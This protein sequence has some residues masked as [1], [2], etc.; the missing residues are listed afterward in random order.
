V[1]AARERFRGPSTSVHSARLSSLRAF[2]QDD[3]FST[4]RRGGLL[5]CRCVV[6][7]GGLDSEDLVGLDGD[8]YYVAGEIEICA[9]GF[10]H[11]IGFGGAG[12]SGW[13]V[14]FDF[15][16]GAG[17]LVH[18]EDESVGVFGFLMAVR[19]T[20]GFSTLAHE[21]SAVSAPVWEKTCSALSGSLSS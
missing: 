1:H 12:S 7:V 18:A 15:G 16:C 14:E 17:P 8:G 5:C 4:K 20:L 3:D 2:A 19:V 6:W 9:F 13:D 11:Q 10:F 21:C